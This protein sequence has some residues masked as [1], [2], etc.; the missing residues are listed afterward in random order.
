MH[1]AFR[2][3]NYPKVEKRRKNNPATVVFAQ[4]PQ[5]KMWSTQNSMLYPD[6][7][8]LVPIL[9]RIEL[10]QKCITVKYFLIFMKV[11]PPPPPQSPWVDEWGELAVLNL[12]F[13]LMSCPWDAA[14]GIGMGWNTH[15]ISLSYWKPA[16]AMVITVWSLQFL[17]IQLLND[18]CKSD[19]KK[20]QN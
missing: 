9:H 6:N 7:S 13:I 11:V 2:K 3:L 20:P 16:V 15:C 4:P 18:V 5:I 14:A 12:S 10:N 1:S 17:G 8:G 19:L